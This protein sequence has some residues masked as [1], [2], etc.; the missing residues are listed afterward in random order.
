MNAFGR[1]TETLRRFGI[2]PVNLFWAL[3]SD[4]N[5]R[6]ARQKLGLSS[7]EA[8]IS[9]FGTLISL[10]NNF[11]VHVVFEQPPQELRNQLDDRSRSTL[12]A[13]RERFNA[14]LEQYEG[15]L[16]GLNPGFAERHVGLRSFHH[17]KPL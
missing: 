13:C 2:P 9:E 15:F 1:N 17:A 16:R 10:Y 6:A 3:W 4:F 11:V 5:E 12:N 8:M 7:F 14:F